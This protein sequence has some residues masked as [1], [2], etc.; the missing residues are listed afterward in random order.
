MENPVSPQSTNHENYDAIDNELANNSNPTS[1]VSQPDRPESPGSPMIASQT[2]HSTQGQGASF[3][4]TY[5]SGLKITQSSQL[6]GGPANET[7]SNVPERPEIQPRVMPAEDQPE[8]QENYQLNEDSSTHD[9][10]YDD[11]EGIEDMVEY[12]AIEKPKDKYEKFKKFHKAA[13]PL[14]AFC[15]AKG[16]NYTKCTPREY[17]KGFR[18][19]E[20]FITEADER[21]AAKD[22]Y[23]YKEGESIW[24]KKEIEGFVYMQLKKQGYACNPQEF[25]ETNI[26][27]EGVAKNLVELGKIKEGERIEEKQ[28][29]REKIEKRIRDQ[30]DFQKRNINDRFTNLADLE[31]FK[32]KIAQQYGIVFDD[33]STQN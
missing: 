3:N 8:K 9:S 27:M 28:T 1:P 11:L 12:N 16:I 24:K 29:A 4:S 10:F 19:D 7:F 6:A 14:E 18:E 30:L 5:Q 2:Q 21:K 17:Y 23:E 25:V 33:D 13:D 20:Q 22:L 31:G 26:F 32:N 15:K